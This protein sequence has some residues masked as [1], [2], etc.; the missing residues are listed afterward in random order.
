MRIIELADIRR[1]VTPEA[2]IAAVEEGFA[3]F[4][5]GEVVLPPVGYLRFDQPPGDTHIKFGY[6]RGDPVF[7]VKIASGFPGNAALGLN[8]SSGMMVVLSARTGFPEAVLLDEGWLTDLR[9]AAAGAVAARWLAPANVECIGIVGSGT[10]ARL[11]LDLLR[12]VTPCRRAVIWARDPVKASAVAVEG[13]EIE[14][15]SSIEQLAAR[16]RLIVMTTAS[17]AP[18]LRAGMVRPGT[19]ITAVG[20]D[21]PGKQELDAGLFAGA[22]VLAVDS[23]E[24]C[25]DHGDSVHALQA[26]SASRERFVELGE[27]IAGAKPGRVDQ[28]QITIA[29]LTGLAIQDIQV[30]KLACGR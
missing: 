13:F 29:D 20:A 7:V 21:A 12:Y 28:K 9:T 27:I 17:R 24:Q 6:R 4:S 11:Q 2:A 15:I 23:R 26:G 14:V 10:Q 30:A 19:H 1:R 16:S 25:F 3:A 5:R 18:L 8:T 22:A